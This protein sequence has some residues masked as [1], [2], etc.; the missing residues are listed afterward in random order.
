VAFRCF[1][2]RPRIVLHGMGG[3]T[4]AET[5]TGTKG[6]FTP[7]RGIVTSL[8][9]PL[10]ALIIFGLPAYI[11]AQSQ[12]LDPWL[13]LHPSQL[14]IDGL[15]MLLAQLVFINVGWSLLNLIPVLPLDG[16]AVTASVLELVSPDHGRRIANVVSIPMAILVGYLGLVNNFIL[17]PIMSAMFIGMNIAELT[18]RRTEDSERELAEATRALL[19]YDPARAEYLA[20]QALAH[21]LDADGTRRATELC[22]WSRLAGG[23]VP[24][25]H[26]VLESMRVGPGQPTAAVQGALALASGDAGRGVALLAWSFAHDPDRSAQLLGAIATAQAG[27][28]PAVTHELLQMGSDGT[29]GA[30]LLQGLLD[31]SGHRADASAVGSMLASAA[32]RPPGW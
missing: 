11:Y 18:R 17:A 4:S 32:P 2:L 25:A 6:P 14:Q 5:T 22:A 7:Q 9:G 20:R 19:A 13:L 15:E 26:M 24:G 27:Q 23:D 29:R 3:V 21:G 12:G 30:A 16:G 1:G 8:A 10:S 31:H 28:V